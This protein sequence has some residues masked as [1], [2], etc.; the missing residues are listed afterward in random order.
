MPAWILN[1]ILPLAVKF[2]LEWALLHFPKLPE[3]VKKILQDLIDALS[4]SKADRKSAKQDEK[5]MV[6]EAKQKIKV[7]CNGVGCESG[8]K[9]E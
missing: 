4:A 8:L 2:G 3:S 1:I 7:A 9:G 6:R 5:E